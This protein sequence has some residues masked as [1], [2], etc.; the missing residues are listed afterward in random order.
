MFIL[1]T[2]HQPGVNVPLR[3]LFLVFY[4]ENNLFRIVFGQN[5]FIVLHAQPYLQFLKCFKT[6]LVCLVCMITLKS[7]FVKI[8][9]INH[10][11][12]FLCFSE[13]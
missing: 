7:S 4:K 10:V 12:S 11:N 1:K 2:R 6:S 5:F 9:V 13:V 8:L 3:A